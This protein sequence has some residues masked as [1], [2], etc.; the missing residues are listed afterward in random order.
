MLASRKRLEK[1]NPVA[2]TTLNGD[3]GNHT[4]TPRRG[5]TRV[6]RLE[7]YCKNFAISI[8]TKQACFF[9]ALPDWRNPCRGVQ[10]W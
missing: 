3:F 10:P 5:I 9:H 2:R 4:S 1:T 6:A 8:A 7:M